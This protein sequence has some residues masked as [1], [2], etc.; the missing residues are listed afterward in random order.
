MEADTDSERPVLVF[1]VL[2]TLVD[3]SGSLETHVST[4][5]AAGMRTAYIPR[6]NGDEP[7][8][9]DDFDI[10]ATSFEDFGAQL[11]Q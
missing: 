6:P 1:D 11:R 3:Q 7:R 9:D 2:G 4:I 8:P 5:A 10:M